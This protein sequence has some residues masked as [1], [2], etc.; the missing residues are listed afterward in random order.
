MLEK[1]NMPR[2]L[3]HLL[4]GI[5]I[6]L[7]GVI[8]HLSPAGLWME[9]KFGLYWLFHLRGAVVAPDN[10]VVVAIDQPSASRFNLPMTPQLWPRELH[11][12]LIEQLTQAGARTIVFDLIFD[13]P[14]A[15]VAYDHKLAL[16]MKTA[17][18]I[19]L[20]ERLVYEDTALSTDAKEKNYTRMVKE[21]PMPLLPL[22]ADAVQAHAP[23]PLPK[24]ERVNH[25]WVFKPDAGDMPTIPTVVLQIFALPLYKDFIRLLRT[26]NPAYAAQLPTHKEAAD[27]EDLIFTLRDLFLNETDLAHRLKTELNRDASLNSTQRNTLLALLN[28]YSGN[29]TRYLN[30]YGPP[31]SIQTIPYHQALYPDENEI[32]GQSRSVNFQN[33]VVFVGFSAATQSIYIYL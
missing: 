27:I 10:V 25:Y 32:S 6:G 23:F 9:E 3:K 16:S 24:K 18:N 17:G 13:T 19:V 1:I 7:T 29:D 8:V 15:I 30:F 2:W 20:V 21:G 14:S 5:V 4:L 33:K 22:I 31:R 26:V 11:A 12:R 28:T